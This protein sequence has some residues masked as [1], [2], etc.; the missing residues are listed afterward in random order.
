MQVRWEA[1]KFFSVGM[2]MAHRPICAARRHA[3]A[4]FQVVETIRA[5]D[6][7]RIGGMDESEKKIRMRNGDTV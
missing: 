4:A 6:A 3:A 1:F 2:S 7:L 5:R